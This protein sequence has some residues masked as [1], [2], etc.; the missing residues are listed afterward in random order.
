MRALIAVLLITV[1][2]A[3]AQADLESLRTEANIAAAAGETEA[4]TSKLRQILDLTPDDGASHYQLATLLMDNNG[5]PLDAVEHFE[6]ARDLK[7]QP[8]SMNSTASQSSNFGW[9]GGSP[10]LPKSSLVFTRPVPN[11]CC[12]KRLIVTRAVSGFSGDVNHS[13]S[14]ARPLVFSNVLPTVGPRAAI[15]ARGTASPN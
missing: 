14:S 9:L 12:H 4:A 5:D 8:L 7:F 13:A 1:L 10:W 2:T 3:T 15:A 11:G 6:R